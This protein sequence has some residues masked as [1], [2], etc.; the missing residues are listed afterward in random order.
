MVRNDYPFVPK[1][2]LMMRR[3]DYWPL[4]CKDGSYG[5]CVFLSVWGHLHSGFVVGVLGMV[6]AEPKI[7]ESGP[8]IPILEAAHTHVKTFAATGA[9]I[10]GNIKA[11]LSIAEIESYLVS[12]EKVSVV[13]GYIVPLDKV[14]EVRSVI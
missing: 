10:V 14:N 13:W 5:F 1:T 8:V 12:L 6:S 2:S 4:L 7:P 9:S 3:G 11:R